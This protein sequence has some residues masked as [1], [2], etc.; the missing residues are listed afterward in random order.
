MSASIA[1]LPVNLT[2][3]E[4]E[5]DFEKGEQKRKAFL[6]E[7]LCQILIGV[8]VSAILAYLTFG[9]LM[10]ELLLFAGII[11]SLG[12]IIGFGFSYRLIRIGKQNLACLLLTITQCV[13]LTYP[14]YLVGNNISI[15]I[16]WLI[17][18]ALA[19]T[20]LGMQGVIIITG[21]DL[22][23][24][25]LV[26][27]CQNILKI[28]NPP[29]VFSPA[30]LGLANIMCG[31]MA[32]PAIVTLL[33]IATRSQYRA[34]Q[35]Q[36]RRLAAALAALEV[37]QRSGQRFSNEVLSLVHQLSASATEQ[38]VGTQEQVAAV[39]EVTSSLEELSESAA[40][41]AASA[42]SASQAAHQTVEVANEVREA[43]E[44]AKSA[45][46]EGTQ[47]VE[48][49]V[50][51]VA[52]VR[53]RIELLGQRLLHLTEQTRQVSTIIDII[54]DIADE[55]HLLALN[56]SIEAAGGIM[57]DTTSGP[58]NRNSVRGERF[59]VIAQE[60][61][62]LSDRSREATEEVR[63]SITEMQGAVAA[64]VLVAEEGK[65]ETSAALT[66]SQ[67]AG[68]VIERLNEVIAG[69]ASRATQILT[70]TE[71]VNLRCDEISLATSQQR[72]ANQQILVTMRNIAEVSHQ[73][74]S[75]V[76]QLSETASAV[77]AQV[78]ELNQVFDLPGKPASASSLSPA[79][80]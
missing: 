20:L 33:V 14:T 24:I 63:Q 76:S 17:P 48:Q 56:A 36:N 79:L 9:I 25:T 42:A 66:R 35:L 67:I 50:S 7:K 52:H 28:Y 4:I 72:T 46:V 60:V 47:A 59:G 10:G 77:N 51:S 57:S 16:F 23:V 32:I 40:Q 41:I 73:S 53:N 62:N 65:K 27:V 12:A 6:T 37:R 3:A 55:T 70:A 54:E 64:A 69:S 75:V 8:Q 21:L 39:S 31:V 18:V 15:G 26:S 49:A 13:A 80:V 43:S 5:Q 74:A 78:Y 38:M 71:E 19:I 61:K 30:L 11:I 44:M 68:A 45:V 2:E 1:A 22:A 58:V 34:F 29:V